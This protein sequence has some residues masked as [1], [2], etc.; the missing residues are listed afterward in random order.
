MPVE[1]SRML[2]VSIF[3]TL[4]TNAHLTDFNVLLRNV[5]FIADEVESQLAQARASYI[6]G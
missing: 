5:M 4:R 6:C 1:E 2:E 3:H